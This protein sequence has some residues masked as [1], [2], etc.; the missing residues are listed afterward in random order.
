VTT[1]GSQLALLGGSPL[2]PEP[3]Q[4][5]AWPPVSEATARR[6]T[7]VYLSRQW[8]FHSPAEREFARDFAAYHDA[9][10]GI[11]MA[12]GTVTLQ[13]ALK[14]L[15]V[16]P[17]DEVIVPALTWLAT[18]MAAHYVG[19]T[20]VFV[21]VEP[22]TLCMDPRKLEEAITERTRA[23][24]PVHLYGSMADM[25][26]IMHVCRSR[27]LHVVEDCAHMHGG[28]WDGRGVGSIGAVGSFSLQQSKTLACG[29]G[30]ICITNDAALAE[31]IFRL[32]HI[33]YLPEDSQ[34]APGGAPPAGLVCHNFR[35]TAF[36][37]VILQEQL[38][39]L[40]RLLERYE[41]NARRIHE[42]LDGVPGVRVQSRG[43]LATVQ[44]YYALVFLFDEG[45]CSQVPLST[46]LEAL[47]AEGLP[48]G[49]TYGPVYRHELFNL[50]ESRFRLPE[51]GCP[52]AEHVGTE[53]AVVIGH[54][55]LGAETETIDAVAEIV[56]KVATHGEELL[57]ARRE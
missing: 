56:A 25:E 24:V 28:K 14:A 50:D 33:G 52:V 48:A 15:G 32:K 23:A 29:E 13:C 45:P 18:A 30:G 8:S 54:Q 35:A 16:G 21:D 47:R 9:A 36:Q 7:E 26:R 40:P 10:H 22:D 39:E 31:R 34:G 11:F 42:R 51:G 41:A 19:A 4:P 37:A 17:G 27:G 57:N 44:G 43:R 12:N 53:S 3:L 20:P 1:S 6:L 55:W 49:G 2:R 5:P 46:I 38:Q